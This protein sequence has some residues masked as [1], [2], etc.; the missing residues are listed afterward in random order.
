MID[1]GVL[2]TGGFSS[3]IDINA[4]GDIVGVSDRDA[5]LVP[6]IAFAWRG[7]V[8][9]DL[10]MRRGAIA[11]FARA[12]NRAGDIA[13]EATLASGAF[14]ALLWQRG[15]IVDL[16]TLRGGVHSIAWDINDRGQIAG[17]SLGEDFTATA[18]IW[19]RR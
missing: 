9:R 3:A 18:V 12:I 14:H 15:R 8:M 11:S 1:L 10:G 17:E 7:G 13:G 6:T 19:S 4:R 5:G 16:G 2:A